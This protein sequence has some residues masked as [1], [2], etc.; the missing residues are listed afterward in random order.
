MLSSKC[1]LRKQI[2]SNKYKLPV[3][4]NEHLEMRED[5]GSGLLA[6][7]TVNHSLKMTDRFFV[8]CFI[9]FLFAVCARKA[10]L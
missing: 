8:S 6:L 3:C 7:L 9:S 2:R 4:N 1:I 5:N 10:G